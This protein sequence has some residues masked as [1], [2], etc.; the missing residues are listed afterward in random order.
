M[1]FALI[2]DIQQDAMSQH[3]RYGSYRRHTESSELSGCRDGRSQTRRGNRQNKDRPVFPFI[4]R[5]KNRNSQI[6]NHRNQGRSKK[7]QRDNISFVIPFAGPQRDK[8]PPQQNKSRQDLCQY[9][10]LDTSDTNK[11]IGY[12]L[13]RRAG[14]D[15]CRNF[16]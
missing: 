12:G 2:I 13:L 4:P 14:S 1:N 10:V 6:L 9:D 8:R 3:D 7:H 11:Q 15:H 5:L 16:G